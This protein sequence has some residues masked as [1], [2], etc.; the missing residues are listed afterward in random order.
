MPNACVIFAA[1]EDIIR[2][3]R[4]LETPIN[5][6]YA[7]TA[8]NFQTEADARTVQNRPANMTPIANAIVIPVFKT[9]HLEWQ[10]QIATSRLAQA[11]RLT[12]YQTKSHPVD[13]FFAATVN[14]AQG[15]P[16]SAWWCSCQIDGNTS[17]R[18][19]PCPVE[20]RAGRVVPCT[21]LCHECE[22][23]CTC[24]A[25]SKVAV[26]QKKASPTT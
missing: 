10:M 3:V 1:I 8:V 16:W 23:L 14:K 9:Q 18:E 21:R 25:S 26:E 20:S 2:G 12:H 11:M 17:T 19:Q 13:F 24:V 4:S 6:T 15:E 22:A 7:P 5:L